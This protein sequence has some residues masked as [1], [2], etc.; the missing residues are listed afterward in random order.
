MPTIESSYAMHTTQGV[1]GFDHPDYPAL[2]LACEVLD[3]TE[4]F[5]WKI[6]RGSG[7]AYGANMSLDAES[8]HLSFL[9]YRVG[10]PKFV[11]RHK[12]T[13]DLFHSHQIVIKVSRPAPRQSKGLWMAP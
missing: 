9:L 4:S 13:F 3:A 2:R 12:L 1:V 8:G 11:S 10:L 7:L 5:L 6:I